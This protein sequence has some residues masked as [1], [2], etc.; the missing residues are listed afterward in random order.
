M[1]HR[2]FPKLGE[3]PL[4]F[5]RRLAV[6]NGYQ[7]V[8]SF[9]R[10]EVGVAEENKNIHLYGNSKLVESLKRTYDSLGFDIRPFFYS[11]FGPT[12]SQ[13]TLIGE[14]TLPTRLLSDASTAVCPRCVGEGDVE[15]W[16]L[17]LNFIDI[18]L[19]HQCR[20]IRACADCG[21]PLAW[22]VADNA[23]RN[24][25]K[26]LE[27]SVEYPSQRADYS[28]LL[29]VKFHSGD[30]DFF[31]RLHRLLVAHRYWGSTDFD[32]RNKLLGYLIYLLSEG[33][34]TV[35]AYLDFGNYAFPGYPSQIYLSSLVVDKELKREL[36]YSLPFHD[37]AAQVVQRCNLIASLPE[38][39]LPFTGVAWLLGV[40]E[41][42]VSGLISRGFITAREESG[43][44]WVN[45]ITLMSLLSSI[46]RL[47]IEKNCTDRSIALTN[48]SD[49]VSLIDKLEQ[50]LQGQRTLVS[51]NLERGFASVEVTVA[52]PK[53]EMPNLFS[54]SQVAEQLGTYGDAVRRLIKLEFLDV[55]K[56]G[57]SGVKVSAFSIKRFVDEYVLVGTLAKQY[58]YNPTTLTARLAAL[59]IFPVSGP[60]IDGNLIAVFSTRD[61]KSLTREKLFSSNEVISNSG[62]KKHGEVVFDPEKYM[63][64]TQVCRLL[65]ITQ[66]E[67]S[68]WM[69]TDHLKQVL[70]PGCEGQNRRF[71]LREDVTEFTSWLGSLIP[72]QRALEIMSCTEVTYITMFRKT[73]YIPEVKFK[74]L[75]FLE[76]KHVDDATNLYRRYCL[77]S[78]ADAITGMPSR[79][80]QN[81]VKSG[82]IARVHA[83]EHRLAGL[84]NLLLRS[85]IKQ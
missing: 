71:F 17:G 39:W 69:S 85:Q 62:R 52:Q 58:G 66:V 76:K 78:E 57:A 84:V 13:L 36:G 14:V 15:Q 12:K 33:A 24:C 34:S 28:T 51:F 43:R 30:A 56:T 41:R 18:C 21:K 37:F 80:H 9:S 72:L 19:K 50:L 79:H 64:S 83:S 32:Y 29:I 74:G 49:K 25:G 42:I 77:L 20:L 44:R 65:E 3:F 40:T 2:P 23:C 27:F 61:I 47:P 46:A 11:D 8:E 22:S 81:L 45:G 48:S 35:R 5:L 31:F 26:A 59:G 1:M 53:I 75:R 4:G 16:F 38:I 55:V 60:K 82:R 6:V 68:Q 10:A 54:V 70:P 7:S 63:T 73:G 67:L